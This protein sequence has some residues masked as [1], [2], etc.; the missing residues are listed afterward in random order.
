MRPVGVIVFAVSALVFLIL[1]N[2]PAMLHS[3]DLLPFDA[4]SRALSIRLLTPIAK[5]SSAIRADRLR[6]S[7]KALEQR[8]LEPP[9]PVIPSSDVPAQ[10]EDDD[11]DDL[12]QFLDF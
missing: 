11:D 6:S 12:D 10:S 4:P 1:L 3:A 5:T 9:P 7:T 2:A 8:F